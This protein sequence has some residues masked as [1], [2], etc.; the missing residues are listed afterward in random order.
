MEGGELQAFVRDEAGNVAI[1]LVRPFH[2]APGEGGCN[3]DATG[4]PGAGTVLLILLTGALVLRRRHLPRLPSRGP[5]S[6]FARR[7]ARGPPRFA[8]RTART[9]A[10]PRLAR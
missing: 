3:C 9:G 4:G 8:R 7:P 10:P 5:K 6:R 1:A 2:G